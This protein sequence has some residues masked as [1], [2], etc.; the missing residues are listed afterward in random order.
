[1]CARRI[2]WHH[3]SVKP[4]IAG[5]VGKDRLR[6]LFKQRGQNLLR[7]HLAVIRRGSDP[8]IAPRRIAFRERRRPFAPCIRDFGRL[9]YQ[10]HN[11]RI[12][13]ALSIRDD[14]NLGRVFA[15]NSRRF[16]IDLND[17]RILRQ[18][19][20]TGSLDIGKA[21]SDGKNKVRLLD[22]STNRLVADDTGASEHHWVRFRHHA[23]RGWRIHDRH[24]HGLHQPHQ[25]LP[26][27]GVMRPAP[28]QQN[29]TFRLPQQRSGLC[30][31]LRVRKGTNQGRCRR[32]WGRHIVCTQLLVG[33][34]D[35][36]IDL[37][38]TRFPRNAFPQRIAHRGDGLV[39]A[40]DAG[41]KLYEVGNGFLHVEG[42]PPA[43]LHGFAFLRRAEDNHRSAVE[44]GRRNAEACR[45]QTGAAVHHQN[46]RTAAQPRRRI[47]NRRANLL[48]AN[49]DITRP[50]LSGECGG[51]RR[52]RR[53]DHARK[54]RY[55][56][57][58][59]LFQDRFINLHVGV[60]PSTLRVPL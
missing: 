4:M 23:A 39:R 58:P 7:L 40:F 10:R 16:D 35:R 44:C 25:S 9:G 14:T 46:T 32:H 21:G 36:D 20:A 22:G 48:V 49:T 8:V 54:M 38:D 37:C 29:R 19:V 17:G 34:V 50:V 27:A 42:L 15:S 56:G 43:V 45:Q 55:T 41:L 30:H 60:P 52:G 57:T 12:R 5:A 31:Q 24:M 59:Q 3:E 11:Q 2:D 18:Q 1:M 51:I 47:Q 53:T 33:D 28:D 26:S 6:R 13:K